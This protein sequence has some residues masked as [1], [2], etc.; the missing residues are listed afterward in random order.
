MRHHLK[1]VEN[2]ITCFYFFKNNYLKFIKIYGRCIQSDSTYTCDDVKKEGM[3]HQNG[4]AD[5]G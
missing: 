4:V 1:F 5:L 3:A 2:L